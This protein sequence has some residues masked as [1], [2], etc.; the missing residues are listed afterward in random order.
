M[1]TNEKYILYF[2]SSLITK[3]MFNYLYFVNIIIHKIP[4]RNTKPSSK[5]KDQLMYTTRR[6]GQERLNIKTYVYNLRNGHI[7]FQ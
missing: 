5:S 3:S 2:A 4:N 6:R 1:K 7:V